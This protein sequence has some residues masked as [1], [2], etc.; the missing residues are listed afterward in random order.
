MQLLVTDSVKLLVLLNW[1]FMLLLKLGGKGMQ[2][3]SFVTNSWQVRVAPQDLPTA[4]GLLSLVKCPKL[5][6]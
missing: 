2:C 5:M 1:I 6:P 3:S 4:W